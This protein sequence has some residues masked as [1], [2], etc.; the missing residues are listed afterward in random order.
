MVITR[1]SPKPIL[2]LSG[3]L[4]L[5]FTAGDSIGNFSP[6]NLLRSLPC[7]LNSM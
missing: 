7:L 1:K 3:G 5:I 6:V 4:F 2:D